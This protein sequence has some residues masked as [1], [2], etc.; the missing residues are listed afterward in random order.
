MSTTIPTEFVGT[1]TLDRDNV[2]ETI[3]QWYREA[4]GNFDKASTVEEAENY[5]TEYLAY[6]SV[7][8]LLYGMPMD[9][10][11]ERGPDHDTS[12]LLG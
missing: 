11:P 3:E 7:L 4:L 10:E 1:P 6:E 9:D 8:R 2:V 5:E 12:A